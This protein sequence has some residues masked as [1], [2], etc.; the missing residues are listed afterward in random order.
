MEKKTMPKKTCHKVEIGGLPIKLEQTGIDRFTVTYWKQV[1][2]G[3]NY[4][5]AA[6]E[7]GE[8]I[9]HALACNGDLDNRDKGE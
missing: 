8:C 7:Y 6:A 2:S 4:A 5:Q 3:L 1:K 9:M